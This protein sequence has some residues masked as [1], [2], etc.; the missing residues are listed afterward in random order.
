MQCPRAQLKINP[1]VSSVFPHL[2]H[3]QCDVADC[4]AQEG[5]RTF[6]HGPAELL[7]NGELLGRQL[8]LSAQA[9]KEV[10]VVGALFHIR[11]AHTARKSVQRLQYLPPLVNICRT[12]GMY[13][14]CY[15]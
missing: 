15:G 11:P 1:W 3:S 12:R 14:H 6:S 10:C 8:E 5:E 13:G 4:H 9:C 7:K 2:E